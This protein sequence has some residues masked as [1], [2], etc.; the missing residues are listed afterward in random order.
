RYGPWLTTLAF[1]LTSA[2][3]TRFLGG[4]EREI[5]AGGSL[6]LIIGLLALQAQRFAAIARVFESAAS[7]TGAFLAA[8]AAV[9]VAPFSVFTATMAGL[10]IL[11]PGFT[12]T[13]ALTELS[14]RHLLSG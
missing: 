4:G 9:L 10:I 2:A 3:A 8:A 7:F 14:T 1:G 12:L 5:I 11:V 6:G 13:T